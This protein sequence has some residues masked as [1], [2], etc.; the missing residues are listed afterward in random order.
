MAS[1][2]RYKDGRV[3]IVGDYCAG[4][5][6]VRHKWVRGEKRKAIREEGTSGILLS[7]MAIGDLT[8]YRNDRVGIFDRD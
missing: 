1:I 6:F 8:E 3:A 5:P 4:S 2:R 7:P